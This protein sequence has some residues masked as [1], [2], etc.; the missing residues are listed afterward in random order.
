MR[1]CSWDEIIGVQHRLGS[2]WLRSSLAEKE[3][4]VLV[5]NKQ[6]WNLGWIYRIITRRDRDMTACT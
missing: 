4:G 3:L 6:C 1:S 5:N 2:V